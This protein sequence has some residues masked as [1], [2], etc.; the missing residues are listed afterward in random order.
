MTMRN[1]WIVS[2]LASTLLAASTLLSAAPQEHQL[3]AN[4]GVTSN[5]MW[6]GLTQSND[7]AAAS[8]GVDY[9]HK[10]G[11]YAGV[12]SSSLDGGNYELDLYG[13]YRGKVNDIAYDAGLI[14]YQYPVGSVSQDVTELYLNADFALFTAQI[15]FTIDKDN[16]TEDNDIYASIGTSVE[17]KKDVNLA[18]LAGMYEFDAAS[19]EDYFHFRAAL[20]KGE[21]TFAIDK[22]DKD[23]PNSAGDMRFS[24]SWTH[25]FDL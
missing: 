10:S 8:G 16:S 23:T 17:V 22:N 7:Q 20:S 3:S 24:A 11:G 14:I 12:W 5:Y 1:P 21:Y 25:A 13:G 4:F 19:S 15:A 18:L 6:R 2:A 9:Q